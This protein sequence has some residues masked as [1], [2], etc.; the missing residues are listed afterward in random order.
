MGLYLFGRF[1]L[2]RPHKWKFDLP[3]DP[4]DPTLD[5]VR[6]CCFNVDDEDVVFVHDG[7]LHI[8]TLWK[9]GKYARAG[10]PR[11]SIPAVS[12]TL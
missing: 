5:G 9:N 3:H 11:C 12:G 10:I 4:K 7:Q 2:P 1:C 6:R 8:R